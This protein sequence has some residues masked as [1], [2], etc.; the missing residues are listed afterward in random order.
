MWVK[1]MAVVDPQCPS[2]RTEEEGVDGEVTSE[3]VQ[4]PVSSVLHLRPPPIADDIDSEGAQEELVESTK[5]G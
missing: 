2:T 1:G 3:G 5:G 4:L